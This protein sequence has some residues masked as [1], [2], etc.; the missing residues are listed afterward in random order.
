[1]SDITQEIRKEKESKDA[2]QPVSQAS[3]KKKHTSGRD[4]TAC[5]TNRWLPEC[6]GM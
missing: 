1:M 6:P 5:Q 4:Y 2:V 3:A